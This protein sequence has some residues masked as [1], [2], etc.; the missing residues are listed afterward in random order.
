MEGE[1]LTGFYI[2]GEA[3]AWVRESH[4]Q[5]N[6][7]SAVRGVDKLQNTGHPW[8]RMEGSTLWSSELSFTIFCPFQ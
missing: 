3:A 8:K 2:A 1:L 6:D 5:Q 7:K 4:M